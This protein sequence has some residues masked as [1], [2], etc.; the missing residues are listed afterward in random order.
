[1]NTP[2]NQLDEVYDYDPK[3]NYITASSHGQDAKHEEDDVV[4]VATH[5]EGSSH[6]MKQKGEKP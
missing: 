4:D 5:D 3:E 2:Q 6:A 1:L